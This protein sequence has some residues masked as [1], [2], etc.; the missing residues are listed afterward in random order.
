MDSI[1]KI[2]EGNLHLKRNPVSLPSYYNMNFSFHM[3]R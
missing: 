2:V 3:Q 1:V